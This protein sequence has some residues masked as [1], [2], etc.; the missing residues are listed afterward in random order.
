MGDWKWDKKERAKQQKQQSIVEKLR[1]ENAVVSASAIEQKMSRSERAGAAG[2]LTNP[3]V[4]LLDQFRN[5]AQ[6]LITES[7]SM[8][9]APPAMFGPPLTR[10]PSVPPG[11]MIPMSS[12]G[13]MFFEEPPVP[14]PKPLPEETVVAAIQAYRCWVVPMFKDELRS[15]NSGVP[16]PAYK[17]MEADCPN[18]ACTG[19][20]CG[21][22]LYAFKT[23]DF[24]RRDY[25]E[26]TRYSNRVFGS[27][28]LWG[29]VL[30]CTKGY[31]AQFAYP[32]Y[33]VDTG[34]L[35]RKMAHV[36]GVEVANPSPS[37]TPSGPPR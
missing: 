35:A 33:F 19:V 14:K 36:Y 22:G 20:K 21:C 16:W 1:A 13:A 34:T 5:L 17:R 15:M 24:A 8:A 32:K 30:E 18:G 28:W 26:E 29:R 7:L 10:W 27:V 25:A 37:C 4:L 6:E 12:F 2:V 9:L 3:D 23:L 31:R 11:A